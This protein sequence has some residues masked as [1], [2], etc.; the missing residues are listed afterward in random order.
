MNLALSGQYWKVLGKTDHKLY[1]MLI[2]PLCK[3]GMSIHRAGEGHKISPEGIVSP[4]VVCPHKPC[5][6]H[7]FIKLLDWN[8]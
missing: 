1:V 6:W 4:S 8:L 7:T 2:C 3:K 5:S